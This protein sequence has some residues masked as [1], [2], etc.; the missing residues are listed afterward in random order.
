MLMLTTLN[1]GLSNISLIFD[2]NNLC[3]CFFE[4]HLI[5][6]YILLVMSMKAWDKMIEK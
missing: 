2:K 6:E 1:W 5:Q 4:A 3:E